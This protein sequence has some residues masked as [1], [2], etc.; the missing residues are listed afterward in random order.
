MNQFARE[1]ICCGKVAYF[2]RNCAFLTPLNGVFAQNLG[3]VRCSKLLS[4]LIA[5]SRWFSKL[6]LPHI[7]SLGLSD[8]QNAGR[9]DWPNIAHL[10]SSKSCTQRTPA[11]LPCGIP[12]IGELIL[13]AMQHAPQ[14]CL[15]FI[16]FPRKTNF[17]HASF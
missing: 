11:G 7:S 6:S 5:Y 4:H 17:T 16:F 8:A 1:I 12:G 14:P 13:G 3:A 10:K 15:Q 9:S 2:I